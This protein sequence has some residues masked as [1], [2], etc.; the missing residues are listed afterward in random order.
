L[1]YIYRKRKGENTYYYLRI[2]VRHKD[3][4]RSIDVAYLGKDLTLKTIKNLNLD[5]YS[6]KIK[7]AI[8]KIK[9]EL[10]N[11]YYKK[12]ISELKLK[13]DI[14]LTKDELIQ[15][16]SIKLEFEKKLK[17]L[18][19]NDLQDMNLEFVSAFVYNSSAIEGNTI[20]LKE[21]ELLLNQRITPKDKQI[22]EVYMLENTEL[23]M[24]YIKNNTPEINEETIIKIHDLLVDRIDVRKGY[25]LI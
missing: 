1:A 3:I 22:E 11:E 23:A 17:S 4:V 9:K 2:S 14:F 5:K 21:V 24:K 16:E 25:P 10:N 6:T 7:D 12:K 8:R 15:I 13:E 20:L 19:F 18:N